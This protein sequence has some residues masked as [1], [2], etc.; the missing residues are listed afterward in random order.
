[1]PNDQLHWEYNVVQLPYNVR[2]RAEALNKLAQ[3]RWQLVTV[4][5]EGTVAFAYLRRPAAEQPQS[6]SPPK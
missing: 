6:G 5:Y 3:E 4:T 1:M 2:A